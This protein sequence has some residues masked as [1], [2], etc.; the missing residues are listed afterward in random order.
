MCLGSLNAWKTSSRG[1]SNMRVM[2]MTR[3]SFGLAPVAMVMGL[4]L[5]CDRRQQGIRPLRLYEDHPRHAKAVGNHA[6]T[7]REKG[8]GQGHLHLPTV[9]QRVE[10]PLGFDI[11]GRRESQRK[12]L[13]SGLALAAAVRSQDRCIA[14]AEAHMHYLF[15][16]AGLAHIWIGTLLEAHERL[17]FGAERLTVEFDCFLAAAVEK[18]IGLDEH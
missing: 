11:I 1:A 9:C 15:Q 5:P 18:Q 17:Y 2:I 7:G 8:L 14:D 6:E 13:E 10:Q 4:I 12:A 3:S 16:S